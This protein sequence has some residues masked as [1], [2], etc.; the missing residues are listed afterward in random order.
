MKTSLQNSPLSRTFL[1]RAASATLAA[2]ALFAAIHG[3]QAQTVY[4][5]VNGATSGLGDYNYSNTTGG[6]QSY[7]SDSRYNWIS[8]IFTTDPTGASPTVNFA[9][10]DSVVYDCGA[11]SANFQVRLPGST[12]SPAST[13]QLGGLSLIDNPNNYTLRYDNG[14]FG[15]NT[16][17][18]SGGNIN[19]AGG[20]TILFNQNCNV[21]GNFTKTGT[22]TLSLDAGPQNG[23]ANTVYAGTATISTGTVSIISTTVTGASSKFVLNG[24]TLNI[25]NSSVNTIGG[26]T[27]GS[28]SLT[29]GSSGGSLVIANSLT[30]AGVINIDFPGNKMLDISTIAPGG[31][32]FN[33]STPGSSDEVVLG[34]NGGGL[35][36]GSG[37]IDLNS[38]TFTGTPAPGTYTLF[39]AS[40]SLFDINSN[41]T[42]GP[43]VTGTVDGCLATLSIDPSN[44][45][46]NLT[47]S[48]PEPQTWAFLLG[49]IGM[50]GAWQRSRARRMS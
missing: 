39:D 8:P 9:N 31:L 19:V 24:G 16:F 29:S 12:G 36:I 3:A 14:F 47:V 41:A 6:N 32:N 17:A 11:T 44:E 49:G 42:L 46:I 1:S 7:G 26:L 40:N 15:P 10:G 34:G 28:G 21:T 23:Y 2:A 22:G 5:D 45:F 48:V 4:V 50:L 13:Y 43:D 37:A 25:N 30:P 18:F 35:N 27:G 33:L 38:F 20:G